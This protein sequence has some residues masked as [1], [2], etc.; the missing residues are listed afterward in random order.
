MTVPPVYIMA[1]SVPFT[2]IVTGLL[3]RWRRDWSNRKI[4]RFAAVPATGFLL[5]VLITSGSFAGSPDDWE[6]LTHVF[7]PILC[8]ILV[9]LQ[10]LIGIAVSA[11][12]M[13]Q[14]RPQRGYIE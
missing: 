8:V 6:G 13:R 5:L 4:R 10:F 7:A 1:A 12:L 2:A 3:F 9:G 11:L 14:L